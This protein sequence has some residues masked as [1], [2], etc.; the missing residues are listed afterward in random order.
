METAGKCEK[1][2]IYLVYFDE[3][4]APKINNEIIPT[5]QVAKYLGLTLDKKLP[6]GPHIDRK[7]T[8]LKIKISKLNGSLEG[9][10]HYLP[11]IN[12]LFTK[13]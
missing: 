6:F 7:K 4:S 8:Q 5:T 9:T 10:Q 1:I 11:I 12:Y 3:I 13:P 2:S